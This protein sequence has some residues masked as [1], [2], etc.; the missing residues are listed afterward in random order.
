MTARTAAN[1]RGSTTELTVARM[2]AAT[3]IRERDA[4]ERPCRSTELQKWRTR[5]GVRR[6]SRCALMVGGRNVRGETHR[7]YLTRS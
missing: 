2:L 3:A 6:R 4:D 5:R 7:R 1:A